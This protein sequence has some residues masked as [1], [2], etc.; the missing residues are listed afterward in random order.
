MSTDNLPHVRVRQ[1]V[2]DGDVEG[3]VRGGLNQRARE[4]PIDQDALS[5]ETVGSDVSV[6][7]VKNIVDIR[8][9]GS[10]N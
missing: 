2:V 8:R 1:L 4:D 3:V 6:D 7:Y 5:V 9:E 10:G